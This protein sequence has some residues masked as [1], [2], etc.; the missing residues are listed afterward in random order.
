MVIKCYR[1]LHAF[2]FV[3]RNMQY[4]SNWSELNG[5]LE[6]VLMQFLLEILGLKM[7]KV[8]HI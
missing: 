8:I 5:N 3:A 6:I 1:V 4:F 7:M 2:D